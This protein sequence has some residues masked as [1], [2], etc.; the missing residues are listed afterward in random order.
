LDAAQN[1]RNA[2]KSH[3]AP[4]QNAAH[5]K[6][7]GL[8]EYIAFGVDNEPHDIVES[9]QFIWRCCTKVREIAELANVQ[10][11]FGLAAEAN[12][13]MGLMSIDTM[14]FDI[15]AKVTRAARIMTLKSTPGALVVEQSA[16]PDFQLVVG[17]QAE[18]LLF[19]NGPVRYVGLRCE[20]PSP[21]R[22]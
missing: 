6:S 14:S 20:V 18:E 15:F 8:S 16:F 19:N 13:T 9:A 1:Y 7:V 21:A 2:L 10:V 22:P 3:F 12:L 4:L 11:Q 5:F 17:V